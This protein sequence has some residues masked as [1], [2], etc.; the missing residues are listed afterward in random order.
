M[1]SLSKD[2]ANQNPKTI[3]KGLFAFYRNYFQLI[4]VQYNSRFA[5]KIELGQK[6][7]I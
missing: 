4:Y 1:A 6:M 3:E 2:F 5:D 7:Q